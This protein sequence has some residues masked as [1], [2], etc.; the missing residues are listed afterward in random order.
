[1]RDGSNERKRRK[2]RKK[3]K[4]WSLIDRAHQVDVWWS[5]GLNLKSIK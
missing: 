2:K 1:M 3:R 4:K 5:C